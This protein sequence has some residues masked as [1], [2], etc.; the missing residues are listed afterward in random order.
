MR[1]I[2]LRC[3]LFDQQAGW[4]HA[5]SQA[6]SN[7]GCHGRFRSGGIAIA[8][9]RDARAES[10]LWKLGLTASHERIG[11]NAL[12]LDRDCRS[13]SVSDSLGALR[14]TKKDYL[15][16]NG[17]D[18]RVGIDRMDRIRCHQF[19]IH[20]RISRRGCVARILCHHCSNR[21]PAGR[22]DRCQRH[23]W[24]LLASLPAKCPLAIHI[25]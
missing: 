4:K 17:T 13:N 19:S 20:W 12:G 23:Q 15:D 2:S 16:W 5:I 24:S 3:N 11:F 1:S 18:W 14:I 7:I 8:T 22:I 25:G 10:A 21:H 6:F 9:C